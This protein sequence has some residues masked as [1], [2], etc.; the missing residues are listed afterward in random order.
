VN[1]IKL[2][3]LVSI[4]GGGTPD[5][6]NPDFW[7]G[8][9]PWA[10]VK[11]FKTLEISSTKERITDAG[12]KGSAAN[13]AAPGSI[14]VPTRMALGKAAINTVPVA[15]NQDLKALRV[16]DPK[17]VDR[18]FLF[19]FLLSK[20][21]FLESQGQG[22]TVKGITLDVLR[23]LDV[24]LPPIREQQRIASIL[25][26]AEGLRRKRQEAIR[27]V[28]EFLR[29]AYLDLAQR[30][31]TGVPV[32]TLLADV[33]NAAR[34]GPFGSQLLVSEFTES[35]IPVLGIDNVVSNAFTWAAPRF[36]SSEK[37]A[38]LE[39][40][41]VRPGD[42]MVTIMG[43]TG[44]VAIAPDDL[45]TCIST[46]HLCTLTLDR[47]KMLPTYL[48]ACLRWDPE[49]K[50]QTRREAK[51]AIM[52][53]WNMGIVKGLLVN[54][55]PMDVQLKFEEIADRIK[56]MS[57]AQALAAKGTDELMA[58]LSAKYLEPTT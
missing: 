26:K 29:A 3:E 11:D 35:G 2:G 6:S 41:T 46:K 51:G 23:D 33:P 39:R 4:S 47:K 58:S 15:I 14:I 31:P 1:T 22:A 40:Y 34:T 20:A 9:I 43:T 12:L 19:R 45:P 32:E 56:R 16:L 42:V 27:L 54:A 37:Y 24:P 50:A 48:W 10:T 57:S 13:V 53:G 5:R 7:G 55:P 36:I 17:V 49:V 28:D 8:D 25:E 52:E 18:D 21:T 38:E 30:H 44:R